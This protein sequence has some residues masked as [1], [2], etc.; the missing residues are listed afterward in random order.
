MYIRFMDT[1]S[2]CVH[3]VDMRKQFQFSIK[4][5]R[6]ILEDIEYGW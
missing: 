3:D 6:A 4:P 5:N 2:G 1:L